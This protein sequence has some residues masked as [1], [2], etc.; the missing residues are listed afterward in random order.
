MK[1][2]SIL[3]STSILTYCLIHGD[4]NFNFENPS[5]YVPKSHEEQIGPVYLEKKGSDLYDLVEKKTIASGITKDNSLIFSYKDASGNIIETVTIKKTPQGE[6]REHVFF[7]PFKTMLKKIT[8]LPD[9]S[10]LHILYDGVANIYS[11]IDSDQKLVDQTVTRLT[12]LE[13]LFEKSTSTDNWILIENN[14][15]WNS[16]QYATEYRETNEYNYDKSIKIDGKCFYFQKIKTEIFNSKKELVSTDYFNENGVFLVSLAPQRTPKELKK[17]LEAKLSDQESLI[18]TLSF[19][20]SRHLDAMHAK[21]VEKQWNSF[22]SKLILLGASH[23]KR[24]HLVKTIAEIMQVPYLK[25]DCGA[26]LSGD[27]S[28]FQKIKAL[29]QHPNAEFAIILFENTDLWIQKY[30]SFFED[31]SADLKH[32]S[33]LQTFKNKIFTD[34]SLNSNHMMFVFSGNFTDHRDAHAKNIEVTLADLMP[35]P[36]IPFATE[37]ELS[38]APVPP[39]SVQEYLTLFYD[40]ELSPLPSLIAFFKNSGVKLSLSQRTLEGLANF[41][42]EYEGKMDSQIASI[43]Q[44]AFYSLEKKLR[45]EELSETCIVDDPEF[46]IPTAKNHTPSIEALEEDSELLRKIYST[47]LSEEA[48]KKALLEWNRLDHLSDQSSESAVIQTYLERLLELPWKHYQKL[49]TIDLSKAKSILDENHNGLD[50]VK[51]AVLEFLAVQIRNENKN[52]K[53]LCL[54]GP[55]GVGK[56]SIVKAIAKAT[57]RDFV[58]AALGGVHTEADIRGLKRAY[59]GSDEGLI[60][61]NL[62]KSKTSNPVFLLDE[63]DKLANRNEW[64]GSPSSALLEVLD[65]EQNSTFKDHYL[66]IPYDLSKVMFIATANSIDDLSDPLLDRME[67][68]FLSGY[69][70]QEKLNILQTILL[71]KVITDTGLSNEEITFEESALSDT[72]KFYTREAGVRNLQQHID[73]ICRKVVFKIHE[74]TLSKATI[75]SDNLSDYLGPKKYREKQIEDE[76]QVGYTNGLYYSS[77][78]GGVLPI[79]VVLTKGKEKLTLT[80]K[81]G[82]VMQE[83]MKAAYTYIKSSAEILNI[84]ISMFDSHAVHIH[85]PA[86]AT[87]KD[88]PSAGAAISTSIASA[89]TGIPVKKDIAMTGEVTLTGKVTAIG[90]LKEKLLGALLAGVKTVLIPKENV[91]DLADIP[92]NIKSGLTIIPV[93]SIKEVLEL[94]LERS[95]YID[96]TYQEM[97]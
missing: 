53:I 25:I 3:I 55:P 21:A 18:Q 82:E 15:S 20:T 41:L 52:G 5:L 43:F 17:T 40:P 51:E 66:D 39:F 75:T 97:R 73:K 95:P 74:G 79:E 31:P 26:M 83:S 1:K 78:G 2:N 58:H 92:D 81:L 10:C 30:S 56:T 49:Q 47:P 91:K 85:A 27:F 16:I 93:S 70:H 89:F 76:S 54:V 64:G 12:K 8:Y 90:G 34:L 37:A 59:V 96:N 22:S 33:I 86:G 88:G 67:V 36:L 72:I 23:L 63:L 87:P 38:I 77:V 84:P 71:K 46:F 35:S 24:E 9:G 6:Q 29:K 65:P 14:S 50:K 19:V 62:K 94:A 68:I 32:A 57:S 80:G 60:L 13:S 48:R 7:D 11:V 45:D 44:K 4:S 61:K 28:D 69:T 42:K